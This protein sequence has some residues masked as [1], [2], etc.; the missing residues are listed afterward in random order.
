MRDQY[1]WWIFHAKFWTNPPA[2][3]QQNDAIVDVPIINIEQDS[4]NQ[5]FESTFGKEGP[6]KRKDPPTRIGFIK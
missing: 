6:F 1:K 2:N 4:K 5:I 3:W